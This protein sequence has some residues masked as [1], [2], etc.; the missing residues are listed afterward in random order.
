MAIFDLTELDTAELVVHLLAHLASLG[1][2]GQRLTRNGIV[3]RADGR[4]H[5]R[6]TAS[7]NLVK[8]RQLLDGNVALLDLQAHIL[9]N[10]AQ[11]HIGDRRQNRTRVGR[12]VL[13]LLDTEEVGRATLLDILTLGSVQ[14]EHIGKAL[15]VRLNTRVDRCGIV[16][17]RLDVTRTLRCS[18]VVVAVDHH[19]NRLETTLEVGAHGR[20]KDDQRVLLGGTNAQLRA[21]A[22]QQRT[23]VERRTRTIGRHKIHIQLDH[24]ATRLDE[25][26]EGRNRHTE[27]LGRAL[28][29]LAILVDAEHTHLAV[30][31]AIGLQTLESLLR[32]VQ[33][34]CGNVHRNVLAIAHLDLAPSAI[35]VN[36]ANVVVGFGV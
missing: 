14:I 34:R 17:A 18:A 3:D 15:V 25:E 16:T 29:T 12:Y 19:V 13:A 32:I 24:L 22:D 20:R 36:C 9:G 35:A 8:R 33:A 7:A 4:N 27:I 21:G 5:S 6:R 11:T 31:T 10:L 30:D 2:V 1:A 26:F 28:Q 23:Q